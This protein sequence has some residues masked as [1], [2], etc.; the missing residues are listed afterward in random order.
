MEKEDS[1]SNQRVRKREL[2]R[3]AQRAS[4][5]RARNRPAFPEEKV[6]K[7]EALD[8]NQEVPNLMNA[9]IKSR[10]E[11]ARLRAALKRIRAYTDVDAI[12]DAQDGTLLLQVC[13]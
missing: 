6:A 2:D 9:L 5:E 7:L 13:M 8:Q 10:E 1:K 3:V 4:R 11:N 12:D